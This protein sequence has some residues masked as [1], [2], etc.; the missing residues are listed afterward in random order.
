MD[1]TRAEMDEL[2]RAICDHYGHRTRLVMSAALKRGIDDM[3]AREKLEEAVRRLPAFD[4]LDAQV[5]GTRMSRVKKARLMD[6]VIRL[7]H[8]VHE[9][10]A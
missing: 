10:K 5:R 1:V 2:E 8:A 4:M 6:T 9:R 3:L 7:C